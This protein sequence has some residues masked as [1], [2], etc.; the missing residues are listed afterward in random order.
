VSVAGRILSGEWQLA[1][2]GQ[3][4]KHWFGTTTEDIR[5]DK[6]AENITELAISNFIPGITG[7][8]ESQRLWIQHSLRS[9]GEA[10]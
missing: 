1:V 7:G 4:H 2:G 5:Q 6:V 3:T 10:E 8:H 9:L